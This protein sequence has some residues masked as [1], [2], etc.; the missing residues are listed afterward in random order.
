MT[1]KILVYSIWE[2]K[3]GEYNFATVTK[4][5]ARCMWEMCDLYVGGDYPNRFQETVA[6]VWRLISLCPHSLSAISMGDSNTK[7]AEGT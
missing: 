3:L 2:S 7:V 4:G 5:V 1:H 6:S